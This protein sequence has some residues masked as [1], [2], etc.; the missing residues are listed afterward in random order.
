MLRTLLQTVNAESRTVVMTTHN[1]QRA[2]E[3]CDSVAILSSGR[4]VHETESV[5][6]SADRFRE[7]YCSYVGNG[8]TM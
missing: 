4:I 6:L 2:L 5:H 1:L 7:I 8:M 3:M